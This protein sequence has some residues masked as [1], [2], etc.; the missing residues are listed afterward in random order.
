MNFRDHDLNWESPSLDSADSNCAGQRVI[1][2]FRNG[3]IQS[4]I[5]KSE[6]L[7]G[8][9]LCY[10]PEFLIQDRRRMPRTP[11]IREVKIDQLGVRRG[12]DFSTDGMYVEIL[13][14][15]PAGTVL[16]VSLRFHDETIQVEAKVIFV[17]PGIGMGLQFKRMSSSARHKLQA[18]VQYSL[19][20]RE[21]L[22][23]HD[24]RTDG[25]RRSQKQKESDLQRR[26]E[27]RKEHRR[28]S[29]LPRGKS[30][31]EVEISDLK[32]VFFVDQAR[33]P[34]PEEG[35]SFPPENSVSVE[36]MDGEKVQGIIHDI[37]IEEPGFF[38]DLHFSKKIFYTVYMI[39]KAVKTIKYL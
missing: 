37:P 33:W 2:H 38:V 35:E 23:V 11:L 8:G 28:K 3:R 24:R 20:S 29:P 18:L 10:V 39:K 27:L 7:T 30:S 34:S 21:N 19:K 31:I 17:D 26:W 9:S 5:L 4:G 36:F 15:Y 1:L 16:P 22:L 6:S 25:N 14:P 13:A 32:S 12:V